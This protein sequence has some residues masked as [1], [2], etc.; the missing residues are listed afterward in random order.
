MENLQEK[1]VFV[2]DD[3]YD[4]WLVPSMQKTFQTLDVSTEIVPVTW[5]KADAYIEENRLLIQSVLFNA[6]YNAIDE[7]LYRFLQKNYSYNIPSIVANPYLHRGKDFYNAYIQDVRNFIQFIIAY[8][9][10]E[11]NPNLPA[12]KQLQGFVI[13]SKNQD[14]ME[15]EICDSLKEHIGNNEVCLT[16]MELASGLYIIQKEIENIFPTPS[17][18]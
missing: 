10:P 3:E 4:A 15:Y 6:P 9:P 13:E 18:N 7:E 14:M 5:D 16:G 1:I 11:G 8:T 12:S 2:L 17:M